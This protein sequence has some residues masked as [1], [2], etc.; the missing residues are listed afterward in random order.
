MKKLLISDSND[1]LE[2]FGKSIS[3]LHME[4]VYKYTT[5]DEGTNTNV[6]LSALNIQTEIKQG[7]K[8]FPFTT[9]ALP[10]H[11]DYV[12]R[13]HIL[14]GL[15]DNKST[16]ALATTQYLGHTIDD[17]GTNTTRSVIVPIYKHDLNLSKGEGVTVN[18]QQLSGLFGANVDTSSIYICYDEITD[19]KQPYL[20]IPKYVPLNSSVSEV[21]RSANYADNLSLIHI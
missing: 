7:S 15:A 13:T 5:L 16:S 14:T 6:N 10:S 12:S 11:L 20:Q 1:S 21:L 9:F 3:N 19:V 2:I 17:D 8:E 4:I 18:V